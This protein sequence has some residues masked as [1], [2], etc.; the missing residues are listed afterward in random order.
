[1][2][3][4]FTLIAI[5]FSIYLK[6]QISSDKSSISLGVGP[7][8]SEKTDGLI[9][10]QL[11]LQFY[12]KRNILGLNLEY[13]GQIGQNPNNY[14]TSNLLYGRD[15]KIANFLNIELISGIGYYSFSL[16]NYA[17][18]KQIETINFPVRINLIF[19]L[20]RNSIFKGIKSGL[21]FGFNLNSEN[22]TGNALILLQVNF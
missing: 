16:N 14:I 11:S 9:A 19:D 7:Y 4:R 1:M 12:H 15:I 17:Y 8:K 18:N 22:I 3:K 21:G 6:A 10:A 20:Y 2:Q 5:L 13:G